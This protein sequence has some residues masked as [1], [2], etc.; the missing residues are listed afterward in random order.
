MYDSSGDSNGC[1]RI[2]HL[3]REYDSEAILDQ[4]SMAKFLAQSLGG[5]GFLLPSITG[6]HTNTVMSGNLTIRASSLGSK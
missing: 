2:K 5:N 6:H 3:I 4:L 1:H